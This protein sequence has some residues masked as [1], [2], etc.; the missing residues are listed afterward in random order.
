MTA[1]IEIDVR[2]Q[3]TNEKLYQALQS[4]KASGVAYQ[5]VTIKQLANEAHISR[6]TFYRHYQDKDDVLVSKI[7]AFKLATLH[8][9][10][11]GVL[12][13]ERMITTL[14]DYWQDHRQFFAMIDW[15]NLRGVFIDNIAYLNHQV[16]LM[17]HVS[18]LNE[19]FISDTYAGAT[20]A[21]LRTY[22]LKDAQHQNISSL[23]QLFLDV[24]NHYR[25]LFE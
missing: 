24:T 11:H 7:H 16:M 8:Q 10:S 1:T 18:H 22:L 4:L 3:K 12:T 21:F 5:D 20:Y 14:L 25:L 9:F 23:V 15:A 13:P 17:N 6:Q 2:V 19:A